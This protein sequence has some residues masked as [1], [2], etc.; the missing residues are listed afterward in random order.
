MPKLQ[1]VK[2]EDNR[3]T[4][5]IPPEF[6]SLADLRVLWLEDNNFEGSIPRRSALATR[7]AAS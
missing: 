2:L 5:A 1:Q 6:A 3:L 7:C 4:G